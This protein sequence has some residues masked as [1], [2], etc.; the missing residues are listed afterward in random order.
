MGIVY[1]I[2]DRWTQTDLA[3]KSPKLEIFTKA[4]GKETIIREAQ[5]WMSLREHPNIVTCNFVET[6]GG[7]P[8]IFAE[9][10]DAGSLADW[11]GQ[12]KLYQGGSALVLSRMLDVAIQ[13]AWGR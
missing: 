6:L 11:I 7:I 10:V 4:S 8:R 2:Y 3:A 1:K 13:F 9:Y 12:R 5:T